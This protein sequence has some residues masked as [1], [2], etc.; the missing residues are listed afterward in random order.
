MGSA[1]NGNAPKYGDLVEDWACDALY[2]DYVDETHYDAVTLDGVRVQIKGAMRWVDNGTSRTGGQA[3]CRGRFKFYEGDHEAL[4]EDDGI[5]LL[6]VY[7]DD[8][9]GIDV[10]RCGYATPEKVEEVVDGGWY[11]ENDRR[12]R[13]KGLIYRTTWNSF[14][15]V[16]DGD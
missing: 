7:E 11:S 5:Y 13:S 3:R 6:V 10:K 1:A 9:D 12:E 2:L 15:E 8:D 14:L 16:D 4:V